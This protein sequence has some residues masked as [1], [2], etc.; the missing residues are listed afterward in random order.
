[1]KRLLLL[2]IFSMDS[3]S[4]FYKDI[5]TTPSFAE[6]IAF[7]Y[8]KNIYGESAAITQ[9]P[10]R[11]TEGEKEWIVEGRGEKDR[12]GGS[13]FIKIVKKNGEIKSLFHSK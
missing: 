13:F 2:A 4:M 1:M 11:I 6:E 8:I 9:K 10:Y 5:I 7:V 12:A 3:H